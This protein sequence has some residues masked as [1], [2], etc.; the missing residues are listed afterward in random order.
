[1]AIQD[2][3]SLNGY[4]AANANYKREQQGRGFAAVYEAVRKASINDNGSDTAP[5]QDPAA[6]EN[7]KY[8]ENL[9]EHVDTLRGEIL[10]RVIQTAQNVA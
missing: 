2:V 4:S 8:I 9:H 7:R 3:P 5:A 6:L 1:M 10:A